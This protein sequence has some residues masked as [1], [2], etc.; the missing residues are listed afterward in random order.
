MAARARSVHLAQPTLELVKGQSATVVVLAQL[1]CRGRA[2]GIRNERVE[3]FR[4]RSSLEPCW[5][6]GSRPS[7]GA[8]PEHSPKRVLLLQAAER[9]SQHHWLF[10]FTRMDDHV[11]ALL[12]R[13][14]TLQI[15]GPVLEGVVLR[16][17][18]FARLEAATFTIEGV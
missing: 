2:V 17:G 16:N 7:S 18:E 1:V 5:C 3:A 6:D 10:P 9:R 8:I 15:D 14:V 4:H 12:E 13:L 11:L